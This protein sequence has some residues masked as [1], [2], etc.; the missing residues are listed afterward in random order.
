MP[1][2][3]GIGSNDTVAAEELLR[4]TDLT[5]VSAILSASPA[6]NKPSQAGLVAHLHPP[7]RS[8]PAAPHPL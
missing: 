2:V 4:S 7:G 6:Y 8:Q 3:Y 1:L 5:G